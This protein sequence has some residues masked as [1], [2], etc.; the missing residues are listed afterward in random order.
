M[1]RGLG[2]V[3]GVGLLAL[4][5]WL[6][7]R[8]G[9]SPR[10]V[11]RSVKPLGGAMAGPTSWSAGAT[12]VPPEA[13]GS[14]S[15][16]GRVVG[17][18][19][20]VAGALVVAT[21]P[22]SREWL[23]RVPPATPSHPWLLSCDQSPAAMK[24]QELAAERWGEAPPLARATTD[25]QGHFRLQGLE[26]GTFVLWAGSAEVLGLRWDV[27]AGSEDVEVR[28]GPGRFFRGVVQDEQGR[29]LAGARVTAVLRGAGHFFETATNDE[30]RFLLGPLPRESYDV[31]VSKAGF[32]VSSQ[33]G[34]ALGRASEDVT[35]FA[36]G[37]IAGRVLD[38]RGPV[39]GVTVRLEGRERVATTDAQGRF[40]FE[41][42]CPAPYV[43]TASHGGRYVRQ[44]VRVEPEQDGEE[45]GLVLGASLRLSGRITDTSGRPIEGAEVSISGVEPLGSHMARTDARGRFLI[46]PFAPGMYEV[47][48]RA[49]RYVGKEVP[50]HLLEASEELEL[51]LKE[52]ARVDERGAS[53]EV[54][55]VDEAGRPVPRASVSVQ[56][57]ASEKRS[58]TGADG[59]AV[60][61]GVEPGR[62][63]LTASH[64]KP[65]SSSVEMAV[66]V[67]DA[68]TRKVRLQLEKDWSLSGQ[69]L[70]EQGNPIEAAY[71]WGR[72]Q[73]SS[74]SAT[75]GESGPEGRFSLE[76]LAIGP[77]T[78]GAF[79]RGYELDAEASET[80]MIDAVRTAIDLLKAQDKGRRKMIVVFSDGI[81]VNNDKKGFVDLG[82]R[83]QQA[84]IVIDTVGY[85]E[86]DPPKLRNLQEM[87]KRC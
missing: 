60:F 28:V 29:A 11:S 79:K 71:L 67:R 62:Y 66:E 14:L 73:G 70:D 63:T 22:A 53:L 33:H 38:A 81:D 87:A 52:A 46:E 44:L 56:R 64:P 59:G 72:A 6:V 61:R 48:I 13:R 4:L 31:L 55:V 5:L 36:P 7:W 3:G 82:N 27:A 83:A 15:I 74:K 21:A 47:R 39:P 49:E 40:S 17:P 8:P 26:A 76:H 34:R 69:V 41:A 16:Q 84:G 57:G 45:V 12:A 78:L 25:A 86:F 32:L 18:E 85:N 75:L 23:S 65:S 50:A 43:L 30:G 20:P 58:T 1:R 42:L 9:A 2:I 37:R 77:W 54:E 80:H 68:E 35:L 10:A 19:G 24:F 51:T